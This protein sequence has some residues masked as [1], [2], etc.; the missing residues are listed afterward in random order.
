MRILNKTARKSVASSVDFDSIIAALNSENFS[1]LISIYDY[2]KRFDPQIAS[3]V[4][5][6]RFKMC[7]FPMFIT[8]KDETQRIF[9]QNYISKS[10]FR[11]FVF[12][13]SAAVV[14]GFAAFLLEWKVKDLNVFP[15]LKYI[16]PRFFS[17][18]DK[19]RLFIYSESK[20]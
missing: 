1:E 8:C 16:S 11:K 12:E 20:K 9:L 3:E 17:M 14:Y 2:F 10:D 19:E 13:M 7:S 4:M 6:R 18:D 5:K 15:K